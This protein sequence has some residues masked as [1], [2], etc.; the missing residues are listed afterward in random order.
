MTED[1]LVAKEREILA[2]WS[3]A[4]LYSHVAIA[5]RMI[6]DGSLNADELLHQRQICQEELERRRHSKRGNPCNS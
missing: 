5:S 2:K 6:V 1:E 4:D 3:D